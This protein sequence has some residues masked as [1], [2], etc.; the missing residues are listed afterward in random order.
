MSLRR[1]RGDHGHTRDKTAQSLPELPT[2]VPA[3][4]KDLI[5][6]MAVNH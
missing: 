4:Q 5:H 3:I 1:S 2:V 6:K